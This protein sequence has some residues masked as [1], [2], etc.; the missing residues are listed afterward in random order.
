MKY[1]SLKI[2]Q[3]EPYAIVKIDSGTPFNTLDLSVVEEL[4]S[5]VKE[6]EQLTTCRAV[7]LT[8]AGDSSFVVGA[9]LKELIHISPEE[10]YEISRQGQELFNDI[11]RSKIPYIAVLNGF[12]IGGGLELAMA[13]HIRIAETHSQLGLP[14]TKL[15]IIPGFGG[16]QRLTQLVG[17]T[18]ALDL[19]LTARLIDA[20]EALR[21]G[22]LNQVVPQGE[23][24]KSAQ[25]YVE[26]LLKRSS[27][28]MAMAIQSVN[29]YYDKAQNGY[30]VERE[31]FK[32]CMAYEDA[33]E[34]MKA[35]AEKR[36][37]HFKGDIS[38]V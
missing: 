10:A 3:L 33:Q 28:A 15:G 24:F 26:Q 9:N 37:P 1:S 11:E 32:K 36:K 35:F 21:I 6:V 22:L 19:L 5:L 29:A 31:G 2:E 17:K 38:D 16:T 20:E 13:C 14:E 12:A 7:V 4:K 8:G 34:G 25:K 30:Q 27:Y 18:K 23:G